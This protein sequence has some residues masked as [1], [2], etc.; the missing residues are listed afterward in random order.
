MYGQVPFGLASAQQYFRRRLLERFQR[1]ERVHGA[2]YARLQTGRRKRAAQANQNA[3][4]VFA[5]FN[6][7]EGELLLA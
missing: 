3:F 5:G 2:V 7:G 6:S 1:A 4:G